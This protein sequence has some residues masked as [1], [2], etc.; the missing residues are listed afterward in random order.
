MERE[1]SDIN[2]LNKFTE[3][4][5]NVVEKY[6][7]YIIVSGFVAISHGRSRGTEDIDIMIEKISFEKIKEMHDALMN[8]GFECLYPTTIE[9]IYKILKEGGNVR[10][11]WKG[12]ELPNMEVKFTRDLLDEKQFDARNKIDFTGLDVYFPKIE[13]AIAFKEEYLGSDKDLEDAEFLRIIYEGK[14]DEK[15][16]KNYKKKIREIKLK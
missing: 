5:C 8:G 16:I 9:D 7:K 4:F 15:Y 2:I 10:Y 6:S 11:S 13:E 12:Q 14:L 1:V 3:E